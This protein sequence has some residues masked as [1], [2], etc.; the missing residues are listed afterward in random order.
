MREQLDKLKVEIDAEFKSMITDVKGNKHQS[1]LKN[2]P[3]NV[4]VTSPKNLMNDA[5]MVI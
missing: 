5:S 2:K 1:P 4:D 3:I